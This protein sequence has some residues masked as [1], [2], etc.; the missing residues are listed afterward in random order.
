MT[1]MQEQWGEAKESGTFVTENFDPNLEAL[2]QSARA[3]RAAGEIQP[4]STE[5]NILRMIGL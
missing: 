4:N 5:D 3:A 1:T 2:A